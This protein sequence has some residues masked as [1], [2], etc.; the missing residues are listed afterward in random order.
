MVLMLAW[1]TWIY[2]RYVPRQEAPVVRAAVLALY[3]VAMGAIAYFAL[4]AAMVVVA[5]TDGV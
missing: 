1:A 4:A 3:V 2:V 5:V